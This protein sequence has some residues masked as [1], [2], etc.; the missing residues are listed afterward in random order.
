M[1]ETQYATVEHSRS[2]TVLDVDETQLYMR[3]HRHVCLA[4]K[5]R[6]TVSVAV[7]ET[8]R[9]SDVQNVRNALYAA[10]KSERGLKEWD[11][12]MLNANFRNQNQRTYLLLKCM[13]GTVETAFLK[14]YKE[15]IQGNVPV[16]IYIHPYEPVIQKKE[17]PK[18]LGWWE[19]ACGKQPKKEEPAAPPNY[20][21]QSNALLELL[22]SG[23]SHVKKMVARRLSF[24]D[25]ASIDAAVEEAEVVAV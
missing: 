24:T 25:P 22:D 15:K 9:P 2:P 16:A 21:L 19:R 12:L 6:Q 23:L 18:E 4:Q 17:A 7:F 11:N 1:T 5:S 13:P 3:L 8:I 14:A 20:H 10:L